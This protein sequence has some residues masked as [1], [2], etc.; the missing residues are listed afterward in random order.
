MENGNQTPSDQ[1]GGVNPQTNNGMNVEE[2]LSEVDEV[3]N[4]FQNERKKVN[5]K[6]L[7]YNPKP[8]RLPEE[9]EEIRIVPPAIDGMKAYQ[10]LDIHWNVG[11]S[12]LVVCPSQYGR[13]CPICDHVDSIMNNPAMG[14]DEKEAAKKMQKRTRHFLPVI[15]RGKEHEGPKWWGFPKTVLNSISGF[16][17]SKHYGNISD[18]YQGHDLTIT[19]P[20]DADTATIVP[21]PVKTPLYQNEDG[22]AN[23]KGISKLRGMVQPL[24]EVF[25]ELPDTAIKKILDKAIP[26]SSSKTNSNTGDG[27]QGL[28]QD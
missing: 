4:S 27:I 26:N 15:I 21:I 18:I 16:F 6:E 8:G 13:P 10:K 24:S 28:N 7:T 22:S 19:F 11:A 9:G 2:F 3:N 20:Q 23:D 5:L 12:K 14:E 17:K 25:I 1:T